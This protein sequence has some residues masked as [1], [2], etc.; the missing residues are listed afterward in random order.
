MN[1]KDALLAASGLL[2]G[3][4]GG[5]GGGVTVTP[6]S[7]T[8]NGTYTAPSGTAYSPVTV[9][10]TGKDPL[11]LARSILDNTVVEYVDPV[12]TVLKEQAFRS[13]TRLS[14]LQVHSIVTI[15]QQALQGT[16]SLG[17]L[18]FPNLTTTAQYAFFGTSAPVI[19]FGE[20]YRDGVY[21]YIMQNAAT[22][23]L[24]FRHGS[25]APLSHIPSLPV[26]FQSGGS[27]GTLYVPSALISAYQSATNW[28]TVLGYPNNQI[29]AIEGSVYETQ[30]ADGTPIA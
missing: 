6:L 13:C 3:N 11:D 27:G 15:N 26:P 24:V 14:K 7:I 17:S 21:G 2:G 22:A 20:S 12:L 25:V 4:S 9:A 29:E 1:A 28:S 18:A 5:G 16:T 23:T 30:Y 10:V 19:D 8:E